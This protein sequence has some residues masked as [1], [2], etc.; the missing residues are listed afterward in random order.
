ML[1]VL[2]WWDDASEVDHILWA[3]VKERTS[4]EVR[5]HVRE[6]AH[7]KVKE[8]EDSKTGNKTFNIASSRLHT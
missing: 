7:P 1:G 4:A 6:I 2:G 3:W 8:L 5:R